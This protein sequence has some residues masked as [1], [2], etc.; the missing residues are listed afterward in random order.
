MTANEWGGLPPSTTQHSQTPWLSPPQNFPSCPQLPSSYPSHR[1]SV[2]APGL[3]CSIARADSD[4]L[5]NSSMQQMPRSDSTSAP[6]SST[7]SRVS[8]SCDEG[9]ARSVGSV[10]VVKSHVGGGVEK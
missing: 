10:K 9:C 1:L 5:S 4:I 8:G 2:H 3:T 6:D 7:C